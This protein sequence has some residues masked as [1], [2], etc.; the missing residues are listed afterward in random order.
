[1]ES[2]NKKKKY[3]GPRIQDYIENSSTFKYVYRYPVRGAS[4]QKTAIT[5]SRINTD[6]YINA[7]LALRHIRMSRQEFCTLV[8]ELLVE[9]DDRLMDLLQERRRA[10]PALSKHE[11]R[12]MRKEKTNGMAFLMLLI[13]RCQ[14][15]Q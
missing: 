15:I 11:R 13:Q 8:F 12:I 6:T 4:V 14:Y 10:I 7:L 9:N 2:D 5:L 1:M 3:D